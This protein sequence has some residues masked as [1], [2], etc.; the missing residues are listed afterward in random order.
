MSAP[1]QGALP[2]GPGVVFVS[3]YYWVDSH[4]GSQWAAHYGGSSAGYIEQNSLA[5]IGH[6]LTVKLPPGRRRFSSSRPGH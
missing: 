3:A 2:S 4:F 1:A 5:P 6:N